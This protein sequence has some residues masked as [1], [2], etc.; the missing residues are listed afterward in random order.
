MPLPLLTLAGEPLC[1]LQNFS[2][3]RKPPERRWKRPAPTPLTLSRDTKRR[4]PSTVHLIHGSYDPGPC[5]SFSFPAF[6][7]VGCAAHKK[8]DQTMILRRAHALKSELQGY[9]LHFPLFLSL[10]RRHEGDTS[11]W[12]GTSQLAAA[13]SMRTRLKEADMALCL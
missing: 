8:R 13:P 1:L 9:T 5:T 4:H 7:E 6:Q 12:P 3:S 10:S 11:Q 2:P